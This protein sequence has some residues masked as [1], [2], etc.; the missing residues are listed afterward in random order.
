MQQLFITMR[1]TFARAVIAERKYKGRK[2]LGQPLLG[3]RHGNAAG[4]GAIVMWLLLASLLSVLFGFAMAASPHLQSRLLPAAGLALSFALLA[5]FLRG[6][7]RSGAAAGALIALTV[8]DVGGTPIFAVLVVVFVLTW[9]ATRLG[10]ER[11]QRLGIAERPRGRNGAQVLANLWA[12][13]MAIVLSLVLPWSYAFRV[14]ALAALAEAASDTVSSEIGEAFG[15]RAWLITTAREV[16]VG[17]DG[18]VS[19]VGIFAGLLAAAVIALMGM[20]VVSTSDAYIVAL[21][22]FAGMI[23]DSFLGAWFERRG[24]MTNNLVNF[25][26][27]CLAALLGFVIARCC[28]GADS[29]SLFAR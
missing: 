13:A 27:T 26:S 2:E 22:G 16:P 17:T 21:C 28:S 18:G 1:N 7:S 29:S 6:V 4:S 23:C 5:W 24:W 15:K 19:A 8:T 25:S 10:R 3:N 14:A 11:K 20:L 12:S 9:L